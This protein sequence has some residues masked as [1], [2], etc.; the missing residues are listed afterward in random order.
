MQQKCHTHTSHIILIQV[1]KWFNFG[2]IYN[3]Y[4]LTQDILNWNWLFTFLTKNVWWW[5]F[6]WLQLW[7]GDTALVHAKA[8]YFH[9]PLLSH[10]QWQYQ[11]REKSKRYLHIILKRVFTLQTPKRVSVSEDH[12]FESHGPTKKID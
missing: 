2:K 7:F 10:S 3:I 6:Q 12:T 5:K 8:Q 1:W 9:L 11:Y 4:C